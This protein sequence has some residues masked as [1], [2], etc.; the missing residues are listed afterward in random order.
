MEETDP[1]F[2]KES[3]PAALASHS[4]VAC[5]SRPCWRPAERLP[6][7][8]VGMYVRLYSRPTENMSASMSPSVQTATARSAPARSAAVLKL[9][10]KGSKTCPAVTMPLRGR[11]SWLAGSFRAERSPC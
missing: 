9:L 1:L 3:S 5:L 6:S 8:P 11:W 2:R 10:D 4:Y 7:I